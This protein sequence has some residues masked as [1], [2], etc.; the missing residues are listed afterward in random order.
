MQRN[1]ERPKDDGWSPAR[2]WWNDGWNVVCIEEFFVYYQGHKKDHPDRSL[3]CRHRSHTK[4][5]TSVRC[6]IERAAGELNRSTDF[7]SALARFVADS[8]TCMYV[9]CRAQCAHIR[10]VKC[11][12]DEEKAL[13]VTFECS[14]T[15][16][17]S[18]ELLII[19]QLLPDAEPMP[20]WLSE[21]GG[22]LSLASWW[23]CTYARST[24]W[25]VITV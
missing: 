17:L 11:T 13:E 3:I 18:R 19:Y 8:I 25:P 16:S 6:E 15:D 7:P 14:K 5:L 22:E 9:H 2:S 20:D 23:L 10:Q 1:T 4:L 21:W 12:I 24:S